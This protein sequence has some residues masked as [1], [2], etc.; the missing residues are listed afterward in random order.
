M[1]DLSESELDQLWELVRGHAPGT[2]EELR[3]TLRG[4]ADV[5]AATVQVTRDR[6]EVTMPLTVAAFDRKRK[7]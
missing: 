7:E 1:D 5:E 2:R 3:D 4:M 6:I